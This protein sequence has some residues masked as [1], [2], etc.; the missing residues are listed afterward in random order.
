MDV[1]HIACCILHDV[2]CV[3]HCVW[4]LHIIYG[5]WFMVL[6][7]CVLNIM[8]GAWHMVR[9]ASCILL[10]TWCIWHGATQAMHEA[11][12]MVHCALCFIHL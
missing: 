5:A 11:M 6:G 1:V 9:H 8:D 3:V 2:L 12:C 7:H 4:V 10:Y